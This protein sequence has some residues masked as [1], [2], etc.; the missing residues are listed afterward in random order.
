MIYLWLNKNK[1]LINNLW[2]IS[3]MYNQDLYLFIDN[4]KI[5]LLVMSRLKKLWLSISKVKIIPNVLIL[6]H[7][8]KI[9]YTKLSKSIMMPLQFKPYRCSKH[10]KLK[11]SL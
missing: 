10:S 2:N 5:I 7:L 6:S 8:S 3:L 11:S 1:K 4:I 9:N